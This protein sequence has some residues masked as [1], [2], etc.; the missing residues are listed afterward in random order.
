[1]RAETTRQNAAIQTPTAFRAAHRFVQAE[2]GN[3]TIFSALM[4]VLMLTITGASVDIMRQEAVRAD[5]QGTVDRAVLAAADLEQ[6]QLPADVVADYIAKAGMSDAL[7]SVTVDEGLNYRVVRAEGAQELDTFFLRMSGY[8]TLTA[9]AAATAEEKVSNVE[10]SLVLDV[11]G[12]MRNTRIANLKTA[13]TSFIS[14]VIQ[15]DGSPG[16]TTVSIVPYS[17][18]VNVGSTLAPYFNLEETHDY[19]ACATFP[20]AAFDTTALDPAA[21]LSR[22]DHFDPWSSWTTTNGRLPEPWCREGDDL[23]ITVHGDNAVDLTAEITA[24]RAYGNT[25]TDL[26]MKWGVALLDPAM[27]PLVAALAADSVVAAD[28]A[29]R[30]AAY[31]DREALKFIVVMTDGENTEQ[32]ELK[33]A[34]D[35]MSDIWIDDRGNTNPADD[36]FSLRVTDNY[37]TSNDEFFWKRYQNYSWR[38]RYRNRPDG[39]WDYARQMTWPE[40]F[41][42]F[43]TEGL[44]WMM[45]DRPWWDYQITTS[46]WDSIVNAY[47]VDVDGPTANDRLSRI[48]A[49]ARDKGIVVFAIGFEAP[50]VGQTAMKDCASSPSHYFNV[51][52]VD[53]TETFHAI[54][55]QINSLRLTE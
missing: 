9:P 19:S 38:Y 53:I 33:S 3:M 18:T 5:L 16:K 15:P 48:C 6:A 27:Q 55:R 29:D 45:Y 47:R 54:A 10:I 50:P 24:L 20:S 8:D 43:P 39:G 26:G 51:T 14:T 7:S 21:Q 41:A 37:G 40:V 11:S 44:A 28:V 23:A 17:A 2:D 35:G 32:Y 30:P 12:S 34:F 52:G 25:A 36:R 42:R 49:A 31:D 4:I 46:E 1:M 22:L 13:A